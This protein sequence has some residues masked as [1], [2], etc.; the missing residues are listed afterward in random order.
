VLKA[1]SVKSGK[2][3]AIKCMKNHFDSLDQARA[4]SPPAYPPLTLRPR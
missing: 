1:Q 4:L 2:A 3:V